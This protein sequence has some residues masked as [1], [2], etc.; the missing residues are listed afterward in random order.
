MVAGGGGVK[1]A[2][3]LIKAFPQASVGAA[4]NDRTSL[5]IGLLPRGRPAP[6]GNWHARP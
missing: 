4:D 3:L 1:G 6:A 5:I 2:D